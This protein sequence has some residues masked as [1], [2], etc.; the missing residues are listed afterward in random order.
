MVRPAIIG[1]VTEG[2]KRRA[3]AGK[4]RAAAA[5]EAMGERIDAAKE[6][7]NERLESAREATGR[8]TTRRRGA[9]RG[10]Q[11]G[12][13][14]APGE[15]Q[16]A[17]ARLDP[18][19]RIPGLG[20]CRRDPRDRRI[21]RPRAPR[22]RHLRD[23]AV[24]PAR[25][26]RALPPGRLEAAVDPALDAPPRPLDDLPADRRHAD[27]VRPARPR[28][29]PRHRGPRR[30]LDRRRRRHRRRARLDR[31]AEVDTR[32]PSTSPSAGS[33]RSPSRRSSPRPGSGPAR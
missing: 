19:G 5:R 10:R 2:M 3:D 14:G 16:A 25:D 15:G 29:H 22:A 8:R 31:L 6:A 30:R 9:R 24:G 23:L 12:G 17:A 4:Q 18:R 11:A 27:A 20:P 28:R 32:S 13:G 21:R 7:T 1:E 33:V 26:E